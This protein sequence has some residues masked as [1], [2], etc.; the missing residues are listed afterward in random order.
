MT[1][2]A[3]R[4]RIELDLPKC[5]AYGRCAAV[6]PEAYALD[7]TGHVTLAE[8][9]ADA[10]RDKAVRGAKSCPYRVI[11]VFDAET[12]EPVFPAVRK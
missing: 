10:P 4:V 6:G 1:S 3:T 9:A 7:A 8:G 11:T 5:Q 2:V 12:G